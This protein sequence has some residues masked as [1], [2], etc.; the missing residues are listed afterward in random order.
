MTGSV[1]LL[2]EAIHSATDIISSGIALVG[3][4]VAAV[5]PDE[6]HPYGHGKVESL[7][8]FGEAIL[9]L[10]IVCYV[11]FESVQRLIKGSEVQNLDV[12]VWIMAFSAVS[13]FLVGRHVKAIADRTGSLALQGNSQHLMVDCV[14]SICVLA[15]LLVTR[16]WGWQQADPVFAL[17]LAIWM[18]AGA[19]KICREAVHQLIDRRLTDSE[20]A[21]IKDLVAKQEG[22]LDCHR[23]RTRLSGDTRYVDM[24]V[25]VPADWSLVQAHDVA[26]DLEKKI[27]N[28]LAPAVVVIHVD[29][30]DASKAGGG[31]GLRIEGL[32][33]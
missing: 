7:A 14:T 4:R 11:L 25:V 10:L 18:A 31:E 33:D 17:I 19:W 29:P 9:L 21:V 8:G 12:G 6:E 1:S 13:S 28:A 30:F 20:M 26:D 2:S 23:L 15:A 5:P 24:H 27:A 22:I 16:I 32:E 3:V